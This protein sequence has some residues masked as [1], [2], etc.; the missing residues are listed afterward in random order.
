MSGPVPSGVGLGPLVV[1]GRRKEN[2]QNFVNQDF[3]P[4]PVGYGA[5]FS[6][7]IKP[8]RFPY[9]SAPLASAETPTWEKKLS[10]NEI[11]KLNF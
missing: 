6:V 3:C 11:E 2:F 10:K 1:A 9:L 4:P 7:L 8:A 5:P